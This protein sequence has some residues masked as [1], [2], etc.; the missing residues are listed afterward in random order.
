MPSTKTL[1]IMAVAGVVGVALAI[2]VKPIRMAILPLDLLASD[3]AA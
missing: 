1:F 3:A 2:R